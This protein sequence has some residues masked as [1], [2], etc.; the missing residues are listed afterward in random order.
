MSRPFLKAVRRTVAQAKK[1]FAYLFGQRCRNPCLHLT[2]S[3]FP[4]Y[5]TGNSNYSLL[6]VQ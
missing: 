2:F 1:M 5:P 4:L 6:I 3:Q